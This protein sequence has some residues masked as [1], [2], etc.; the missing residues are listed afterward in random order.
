MVSVTLTEGTLR[1]TF[2]G[3]VSG[4][5]FD[6]PATHGLSHCMKAVDFI[7]EF[8]NNYLF[9]EIKDPTSYEEYRGQV[10]LRE[11]V[12]SLRYKF[13]DSL[14]YEWASDRANKPI[15]YYVLI[16][17]MDRELLGLVSDNLRRQIPV[18]VRRSIRWS[19]PI[20]NRF[21]V[22]NMETWNDRVPNCPVSRV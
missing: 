2:T 16:T 5:K 15:D 8:P 4:R 10:E 19:R 6:D 13:R 12:E 3:A 17:R 9:V 21:G 1:I 18:R 20:V 7:V 14:I 11:L 22:F